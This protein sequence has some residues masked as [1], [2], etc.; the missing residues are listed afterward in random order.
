MRPSCLSL[1]LAC[2]LG[3]GE[4]LPV[5]TAIVSVRLHPREAWITREGT[6]QIPSAGRHRVSLTGLPTGLGADDLRMGAQ[7]PAGTRLG[8]LTVSTAPQTWQDSPEWKRLARDEQEVN[9]SLATLAGRRNL[10]QAAVEVTGKVRNAHL[11]VL[12]RAM[13]AETLQSRAVPDFLTALEAR[14]LELER[15]Q[16]AIDKAQLE[17]GERLQVDQQA[18]ARLKEAGEAHST[19]VSLDLETPKAGQVRL[20]LATRSREASWT[21][22]YEARLSQDKQNLELLLFA[23]VKQGSRDTWEG[24]RLEL[25]SQDPGSLELP[26]WRPY[27]VLEHRE[28]TAPRPPARIPDPPAPAP[29]L[30]TLAVPGKVTVQGGDDVQRFRLASLDLPP[31][32]RYLAIPRQGPEV[33]LMAMVAPPPGFPIVDGSPVDLLQGTE[34]LGTFVMEGPPPGEPLRLNFGPVPGLRASWQI[35]ER[36]HGEV[37]DKT[38]EREWVIRERLAVESALSA[39]ADVEVMDRTAASGTGSVKVDQVEGTTPGWR[40]LRP[41]LR[42]WML[43]LAPGGRGEVAQQTRIQGPLVGRLTGLG[44]LALEEK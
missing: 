27:P 7:G 20:S 8:D 16:T 31:S 25:L 19:V 28:E 33:C 14:E 24:V 6:V 15:E 38:R 21:P 12:Q 4:P 1:I 5:A 32:F 10:H 37:G 30:A 44:A 43:H 18:M 22:A 13:G 36:R 9:R 41:G 34:R 2:A 26:P 29:S 42:S 3:A 11:Q 39:P 35:L 40:D 17:L 23:A